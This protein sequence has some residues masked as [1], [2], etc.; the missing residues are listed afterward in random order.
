MAVPIRY[1]HLSD[2]HV[3]KDRYAERKMFRKILSH[4]QEKKDQDWIP[5]LIFITGDI[6]NR[7]QAEEYETFTYEFLAELY[8]TL[9]NWE[10]VIFAV[11]GNHDVDRSELEFLAR[12]ELCRS[13]SQVFESTASGLQKR[14]KALLPGIKAYSIHAESDAPNQWIDSLAGTFHQIFTIREQQIGIVGMNTAWLSKDDQDER[15]LTP[16]VELVKEA[17]QQI[18]TCQVRIVLGHHPIDWF[19]KEDGDRI[20]QAFGRCGVLY[21]HGHL[22]EACARAEENSAGKGFLNIQAGAAF[23]ARDDDPRDWK[24]GLLW[25][26][27][28][29]E[30]Q[31][32]RLQPRHWSARHEGWVLSS[33]AFH[34][35]REL[36]NGWWKF[37]LPSVQSAAAHSKR[38]T[39]SSPFPKIKPPN[40]WN[41]ENEA[42]LASRRAGLE[43]T[44]LSD[45]E[46]LQ[47][48]DGGTPGW[49]IALS[50]VID[51]RA[52]VQ[53]LYNLLIAG[54][55]QGKPTVVLLLGAGGEGK[56]TAVIQTIIDLITTD[57][58]WQVLWRH[59]SEVGL[60]IQDITT[61]PQDGRKWLIASDDAD[62]IATDVFETVKALHKKERDDIQFLL[63]CRDTDW[64]ASEQEVKIP[65]DWISVS[66]L[67]RQYIS[68]LSDQDA[69]V[70]IRAWQRLGDRGL[71]DL[72]G[73]TEA[74]AVRLL[75]DSARTEATI[76]EG[77]FF[78]AMLR[79]RLGDRL[80]D[81]LRV[82]LNRFATREFVGGETLLKAF[83][84]IAAMHSEQ[85]MFLSKSVLCEALGCDRKTLQAKGLSPL[86]REAAATQAG[87]FVFTRHRTIAQ[88]AIDILA[89]EMGED[90]DE[91]FVE[92][93]RAAIRA[94]NQNVHSVPELR[95]WDYIMPE[96]FAEQGKG[97]LAIQ[98]V[99][100]ML[101]LDPQNSRRLVTLGK[102]YRDSDN[103]EEAVQLFR[104]WSQPVND[105]R[106]FLTEWGFAE[107]KVNG[108]ALAVY[109]QALALADQGFSRRIDNKNA[110]RGLSTLG[111]T[112]R[113]A[114]TAYNQQAFVEGVVAVACLG[115]CVRDLADRQNYDSFNQYLQFGRSKGIASMN[116]TIALQKFER[117]IHAAYEL[118]DEI[119]RFGDRVPAFEDLTFKG[120]RDLI[121]HAVD[122]D[123]RLRNN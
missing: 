53:D 60:S 96:H 82:V 29:L 85:L 62:S 109:L 56:S 47:Y 36:G 34:P 121:S 27:V 4:V 107:A 94:K 49:R 23:Q 110:R 58:T 16:G 24:N 95:K 65:R 50:Q 76:A 104:D 113:E 30:Q 91:L 84:Y 19:V 13:R 81:H 123:Q 79:M 11:P 115:M 52:I 59:D 41:L 111:L 5:D 72:A 61:L 108:F 71:G 12:E 73:K 42:S 102:F 92:L 51:R 20:R 28:D 89:Q 116:S 14:Q 75:V 48:F 3:G 74:E 9:G 1:L 43:K 99:K 105:N 78:G 10:G 25:G 98:I 64:I 63:T 114:Y 39:S 26:E 21:L 45:Q 17:L 117:A 69:T 31:Q 8:N 35:D 66:N 86:G 22:H 70:V 38:R 32:L 15:N 118:C 90:I 40:G 101:N 18:E 7:G 44:G 55:G 68:G 2:F 112:L 83:A 57:S 97:Y 100:E 87:P 77:A 46:A 103:P 88:V 119:D 37:S 54:Q 67:Q 106:S 93:C 80:K 122:R 6:A 120:L 33:E